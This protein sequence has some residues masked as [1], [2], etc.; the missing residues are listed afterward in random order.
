MHF[1][2]NLPGRFIMP[3]QHYSMM[4]VPLIN[5]SNKLKRNLNEFLTLSRFSVR[6]PPLICLYFSVVSCL[7]FSS[8]TIHHTPPATP[9]VQGWWLL[10]VT[11]AHTVPSPH[12]AASLSQRQFSSN[13]RTLIPQKKKRPLAPFA[14][15]LRAIWARMLQESYY[16][17][18][19]VFICQVMFLMW[20]FHNI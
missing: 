17:I 5:Y 1:R 19:T 18:I 10:C 9:H 15:Q 12:H 13:N 11:S 4:E 3:E 20:R 7:P 8:P 6:P 2:R 16:N 14:N